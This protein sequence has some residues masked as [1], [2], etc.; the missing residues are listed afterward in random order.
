[1]VDQELYEP[2]WDELYLRLKAKSVRIRNIWIAD[3]AHQG[4]SSVLNEAKL[5]NDRG[6][7]FPIQMHHLTCYSI[8]AGSSPRSFPHGQPLPRTHEASVDRDRPQHG[9]QQPRQPVNHAPATVHVSHP[10]RPCNRADA[11]S[12]GQLCTCATVRQAQRS[13]AKSRGSCGIV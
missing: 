7:S 10:H 4:Q 3:V 13:M 2:L 12:T 11:I 5:G 1:M 8:L 6:Y 9:W